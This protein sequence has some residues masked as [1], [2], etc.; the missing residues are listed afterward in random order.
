MTPIQHSVLRDAN[1]SNIE[2]GAAAKDACQLRVSSNPRSRMAAVEVEDES[3]VAMP[4]K[5]S[6]QVSTPKRS[7]ITRNHRNLGLARKNTTGA[8]A[9]VTH[10][11]GSK[12]D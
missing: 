5:R 3:T 7:K 9:A 8:G 12:V 11:E 6:L 4:A 2:R 10:G 1:T